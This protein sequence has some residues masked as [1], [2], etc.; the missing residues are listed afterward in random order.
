MWVVTSTFKMKAK[1]QKAGSPGKV[2]QLLRPSGVS[3]AFSVPVQQSASWSVVML[4]LLLTHNIEYRS[5]SRR[6]SHIRDVLTNPFYRRENRGQV[7]HNTGIWSHLCQHQSQCSFLH[8]ATSGYRHTEAHWEGHEH[9][10]CWQGV[11]TLMKRFQSV[12]KLKMTVPKFLEP[13]F[14]PFLKL[15]LAIQFM[16]LYSCLKKIQF[17]HTE[18]LALLLHSTAVSK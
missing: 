6:P 17:P 11:Q 1:N 10:G 7:V 16:I 8:R 4:S 5:L 18:F 13:S 9:P 12:L 3:E 14:S 2:I 15:I